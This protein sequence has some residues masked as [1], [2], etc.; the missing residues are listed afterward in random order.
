MVACGCDG[1]CH[2]TAASLLDT[3]CDEWKDVCTDKGHDDQVNA[4][5]RGDATRIAAPSRGSSEATFEGRDR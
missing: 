5:Q 3:V 1:N 4:A 2:L